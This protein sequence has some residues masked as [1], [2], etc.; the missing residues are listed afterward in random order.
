MRWLSTVY[1]DKIVVAVWKPLWRFF[2]SREVWA[3]PIREWWHCSCLPQEQKVVVEHCSLRGEKNSWR[4]KPSYYSWPEGH[5]KFSESF[6]LIQKGRE[7]AMWLWKSLLTMRLQPGEIPGPNSVLVT[8]TLLNKC[9]VKSAWGRRVSF[10]S[11]VQRMDPLR[12][13][14]QGRWSVG[15]L[16]T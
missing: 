3:Q 11:R 8:F 16:L 7:W 1:V 5:S 2:F 4:S 6:F 12:W 15:W 14:R 10:S 9:V 13:E